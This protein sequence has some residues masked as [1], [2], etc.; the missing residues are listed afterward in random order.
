[1][2][3]V[4]LDSI[5]TGLAGIDSATTFHRRGKEFLI[6]PNTKEV[7][8]MRAYVVFSST[9]PVLVLTRQPICSQTVEHELRRI[10][11]LKFF[12][13]EV[14]VDLLRTQYGRQFDVIKEALD[15]GSE[16][17]VLDFSGHRIF[18]NLPLSMLGPAYRR[19]SR[20]LIA[21]V[22]Q[23]STRVSLRPTDNSQSPAVFG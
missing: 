1:M 13:L 8:I 2:T 9:E 18:Q 7:N 22:G 14:P 19:E 11:C 6:S 23:E 3:P 5:G 15:K 16:L 17:R 20:T 10:G 12:A 21:D 4:H